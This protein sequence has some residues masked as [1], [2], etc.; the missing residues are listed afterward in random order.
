M[1]G[2]DPNAAGPNPRFAMAKWGAL[3]L[4][5]ALA[6]GVSFL[7]ASWLFPGRP[8]NFLGIFALGAV[9]AALLVRLLTHR[10]R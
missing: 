3:T 4:A 8:E 6:G 7:V 9:A 10:A 2:Q 1:T 5:I